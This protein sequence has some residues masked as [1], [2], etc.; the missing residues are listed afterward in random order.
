MAT[1]YNA[2]SQQVTCQ[3]LIVWDRATDTITTLSA[4]AFGNAMPDHV[5]MSPSGKYIVPSWAYNKTLGTRAYTRD[6]TSF[7]M[8]HTQS[9]HSDL[10]FGPN[11]EDLYIVSDYDA[12]QIRA[13]NMDTGASFNLMPLYPTQ[14]HSF[15][16]HISGKAFK[17]PGWA[18]VST[19]ADYSS[20]GNTYP[21]AAQQGMYRKV[22]A[23]ELKPGGRVLN[24][25]HTQSGR[26]YGGY[27]GEHQ[28]SVN[29]DFTRVTWATNFGSGTR[30]ESVMVGL[31]STA[32]PS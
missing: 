23:V 7:K 19:Y 14:G 12:G 21:A 2:S 24:I 10:A 16:C 26:D 3:G 20:Y 28:A 17:R 31:P 11:G 27:F 4:G 22:M 5:S 8:L 9:E 18:V 30:I 1:T 15:S 6:F 13:V 29:Q 32:I 25:A